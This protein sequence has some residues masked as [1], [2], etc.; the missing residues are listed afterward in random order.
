MAQSTVK[1]FA[2]ELGLPTALLLEQLK[3]AG[4][5]KSAVDDVLD[6]ADKTALLDYLRKEHGAAKAPK[7]KITLTRKQNSEI[8]KTDSD[9]RART[10]QVEVR[11]KRVLMRNEE[12]K[13]EVKPAAVETP[14]A[15]PEEAVVEKS[16][17][18]I[19]TVAEEQA[20]AVEEAAAKEAEKP[21]GA[22]KTVT[23][24]KQVLTPEQIALRE[25]EAER[26][27]KLVAFQ[28]EDLRKKEE[29]AKRR[30]EEEQKRAAEAE[31]A[32][33]KAA[34][35]SEGTLHKPE[36]KEG[37]KPSGKEGKK[38]KKGSNS[39]WNERENRKRGLKTRGAA[40][41]NSGWRTPK[42]KK[43]SH[44]Q[45]EEHAFVAPTEPVV[46][47]VLVP[48]TISVAEL[49]HKMAVKANEVI[50]TLMGMG[51][52]VTINQVLDQETAIIIVE[53]M[54]HKAIA[55]EENDPESFLEEVD[56]ADAVLETRPPV[57]KRLQRCVHV[58]LKQPMW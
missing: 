28:Q 29:L 53:E 41:M 32:K 45:E 58:V 24:K 23:R 30:A 34:K 52:M 17:E 5:N 37:A 10:I 12:P 47:E 48:E 36:P 2:A 20:P 26:H 43:Q 18:P 9:G 55:A 46:H 51:M 25:Q 19:E 39:D 27:A 21:K 50:K 1:Q 44:K 11:K 40:P 42:G 38:G 8:K 33:K 7:N 56:T 57:V 54:G 49:A 4:V 16:P 31:E 6:E 35:L 13:E 22:A 14:A 3:S 15:E